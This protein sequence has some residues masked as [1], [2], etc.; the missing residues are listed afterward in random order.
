MSDHY[1]DYSH[2]NNNSI[3][4]GN[5]DGGGEAGSV[6]LFDRGNNCQAIITIDDGQLHVD[7]ETIEFFLKQ[8]IT[9]NTGRGP[10][11]GEVV[12][13]RESTN[14]LIWSS[15]AGSSTTY[16]PS[17]NFREPR[18]SMYIGAIL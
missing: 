2:G 5:A 10:I 1:I 3:E 14:S 11:D 9:Q 8:I 6:R 4:L 16:T 17:L 7:G 18:N 15:G 13:Y 12:A